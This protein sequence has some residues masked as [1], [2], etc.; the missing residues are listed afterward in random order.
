MKEI[1]VFSAMAIAIFAKQA[2]GKP[3]NIIDKIVSGKIDKYIAENC[4]ME[5][6]FIKNPDLTVQDLLNELMAKM[7]ENISVKRFARYQLGA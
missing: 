1:V 4:L 6:K 2:E 7:G 3:E 5:Q